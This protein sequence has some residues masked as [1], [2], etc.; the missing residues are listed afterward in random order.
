MKPCPYISKSNERHDPD[1]QEVNRVSPQVIPGLVG[2]NSTGEADLD[3]PTPGPNPLEDSR[4][5]HEGWR[6][7]VEDSVGLGTESWPSDG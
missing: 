4:R 3:R 6:C 1:K 2:R 5:G 7:C